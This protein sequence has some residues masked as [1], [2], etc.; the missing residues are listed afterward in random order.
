MIDTIIAQELNVKPQQVRAAIEL[1]DK[2]DTVPFISRYRKE[3]TGNL[4]DTQMRNLLERL[5]YL[6]ELQ[7][8]KQ[9]ILKNIEEQAKLTPELKQ[10][11]LAAD[12]KVRLEDLYKP[13]MVKRR[14]KAQI[15]R[16]AGLQGLA[17]ILFENSQL[18]PELEAQ[19]Y[20]TTDNSL[21]K[22]KQVLDTKMALD[23]A[24]QILMEQYA[25][26][27][28]LLNILRNHILENAYLVSSVIKDQQQQ[29]IKFSDYFEYSEKLKDIPSHR[30]LA[31]FR[32]RNEGFL[33]LNIETSIDKE[34]EP[35]VLSD[36]E[37]LIA[38]FLGF[39]QHKSDADNLNSNAQLKAINWLMET[40]R[41]CW[42]VKL[43]PSLDLEAKKQ[44]REKAEKA[45]IDVFAANL[46]DLLMA[47][48]AGHKTTI[49]LDPGLRTGVKV[50]VV[51]ATGRFIDSATIYPHVPQQQWEQSLAVLEKLIKQ[52]KVSLISIGN[53][54]ASR[55][56]DKLAGELIKR[57]AQPGLVK[58]IVSEAGAS[59]YSAS[60]LAAHEFPDLDVSLRGAVSIARRLQ[61]PLA[62]LVKI[63]PKAIGVGQYQHDVSQTQL[64][65][66]LESV[67]EDCVNAVGVDLNTASIPLLKNVAGLSAVLAANIVSY[68]EQNG[69]FKNR[70]EL[71]KVPRLGDKAY[72]QCAG[73]LRIRDG[74]NPLDN[75]GVHPESYPVIKRILDTNKK[76][77]NNLIG[78]IKF[79]DSLAVVDYT[80]EKFGD[81]TVSD[82]FLELKKPGRDPRPEFKM[83]T[84]KEGVEKIS[85]LREAMILEGTI[86]NVTNF[87]AFVDI[88]V[89]QDGLVHISQLANSFVKD[90]RS[91]VKTG[92]IVTVKVTEIDVQRKR[93]ALT[94]RLDDKLTTQST[95]RAKTITKN[96]N[97]TEKQTKLKPT[98]GNKATSNYSSKQQLTSNNAMADALA[99][100]IK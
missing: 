46:K 58:V 76:H 14:T 7:S 49:G 28:D 85:D 65:K 44:L 11:I 40:V 56:T 67:I 87:G 97:F 70:K 75:S 78:D 4:D 71:K 74:D 42:K 16:E 38:K 41:W 37:Y 31:L 55:E 33:S 50:T 39:L 48:P 83:A 81:F 52:Y 29:G 5:T 43:K 92:E 36:G 95:S 26:N 15:A 22:E 93:I 60:E 45:A 1:L 53:G 88:G 73:F 13:Y 19:Q 96:R 51:D 66:S 99:R 27:A 18:D 23:G 69:I 3:V 79:I 86:T 89:H 72:E 82:I 62:E 10:L 9:S 91:I 2:G 90:P 34:K 100:A 32:G 68:R 12:S 35:S 6:R 30:A 20:L 61:D 24:K 17:D 47:A 8:R 63:D 21:E 84:L 25:E 77:I 80:D 59:V 98:S 54:T 64:A 94:M 57:M